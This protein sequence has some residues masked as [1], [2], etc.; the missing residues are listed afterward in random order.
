MK[1]F[2][3]YANIEYNLSSRSA[4]TCIICM[5]RSGLIKEELKQK[6]S[7]HRNEEQSMK[8]FS[9]NKD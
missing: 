8:V 2:S 5:V 3:Q 4:K 9:L 6:A 1:A 7:F